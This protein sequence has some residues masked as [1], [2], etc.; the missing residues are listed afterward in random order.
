ML[1]RMPREGVDP[2]AAGVKLA[3]GALA[4]CTMIAGRAIAAAAS[5]PERRA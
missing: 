1:D 5:S 2:K 3:G 4:Y